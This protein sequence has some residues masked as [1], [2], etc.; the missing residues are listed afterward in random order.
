M[1][2]FTEI[3]PIKLESLPQFTIYSSDTITSENKDKIGRKLRYQLQKNFS[4]HWHWDK[5]NQCLITDSPLSQD[6]LSLTLL[7]YGSERPPR[8]PV[9]TYYADKISSLASRCLGPHAT[10]GN[11][12]FWL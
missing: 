4:G 7:H 2:L 12:P 6:K 8:L 1:E 9:T 10:D 5:I 11:I 3:L